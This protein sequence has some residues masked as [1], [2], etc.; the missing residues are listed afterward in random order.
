MFLK[1]K[2]RTALLTAAAY[3][4]FVHAAFAQTG[5]A[6]PDVAP[7]ARSNPSVTASAADAPSA[8]TVAAV[9]QV[10]VTARR[11]AEAAQE[12][13]VS[14]SV[15]NVQQLEA[16]GTYNVGQLTQLTLSVQFFS[17]NPRNT[18]ITIRGLGTSFGLTNDGLESGVGLYIDQVYQSRPAAA[19]FDF[20][21]V[22]QVEVLRGPQ[23]T[24]FGKNTTAGAI[25]IEI[26][27]P[28]FERGIQAEA[29]V[30]NYSF[31]QGKASISGPIAG[32]VLAARLSVGGTLRGGTVHN[33]TTGKDVNNQ[34][35]F[36]TRAQLLYRPNER[37]SLRLTGDYNTQRAICCALGFVSVGTTLKPAAQ[38]F[39]ALAATAGYAPV[40]LDPFDR[41]IDTNSP[42]Q[43][44]Q[45]FGGVSAIADWDF[46]PA[47]LTS[48]SA[49]RTWNWDPASDRDFTK[50]SIQ[51]ISANPDNQNQYSQ[52]FRVASNGKHTV[53][54]VGGLYYFRQKIDATPIAQYGAA[55]THWLL[56]P[57]TLPANLLNG[58][59]SDAIA[60]SDTKS[61]AAF[62]QATW[63]ITSDLHFTP[64]LRYTYEDKSGNYSSPC[65]VEIR[66][67]TPTTPATSQ[68]CFR[69]C[70]RNP[71]RR[72]SPMAA[73]PD[74]Q[75]FPTMS[76]RTRWS[77]RPSR[78]AINRAG[79][80]LRVF[81]LTPITIRW[82]PLLSSS[83]K[84]LPPM[85][86]A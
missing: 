66:G 35:D 70:G 7:D 20:I 77:T 75:I 34:N 2:M 21:D 82:F 63:N 27:I 30:G 48:V 68:S 14:L 36:S 79:S 52:E 26:Q 65:P 67:P 40:S 72:I 51:T 44:N 4:I 33:V 74:R 45:V 22:N 18:A 28:T 71:M 29:S 12:V 15:V 47:T 42:A 5:S 9:E 32:N 31:F 76:P 16:K 83:R 73:F 38:Q 55:A 85:K 24:L 41:N 53:D 59:R 3:P 86:W 6:S 64:G 46:G 62:A 37:F 23:G 69:S 43:A 1:C 54:Y 78:K 10:T 11:R 84:T 49:W 81:R 60:H 25:N 80:T 56:T 19:T 17:S 58:Y 39:P 57:P 61:Y 8:F 13:P 50:L